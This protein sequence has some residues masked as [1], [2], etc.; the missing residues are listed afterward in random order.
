MKKQ[1]LIFVALIITITLFSFTEKDVEPLKGSRIISENT[2]MD[3]AEVSNLNW[4]EYMSWTAKQFG[5][6]STQYLATL[7]DTTVWEG[8]KWEP[9]KEF[10]LRNSE[11]ENYP[12][13][14]ISHSQAVAYCTWRADRIN[15]VLKL[16]NKKSTSTFSCRL[17][18]KDEWEKLANNELIPFGTFQSE[19]HNLQNVTEDGVVHEQN[20][21]APVKS[22]TPTLNG[23]YNLIG[24]VA[25]MV[26][27]KGIAKGGSWNHTNIDVTVDKDNQYEGPTKW[28]G[29][30]C[31][32]VKK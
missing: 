1:R 25:E 32:L 26:M 19:F 6:T 8:K 21:M 17:P 2:Y 5:N 9:I 3:V 15:E 30:R 22:F 4:R 18:S 28:W 14:G 20:L 10:Y 31:V 12:V 27:E 7:P 11:Y 23:Y 24:N 29:F 16:Q 13:V